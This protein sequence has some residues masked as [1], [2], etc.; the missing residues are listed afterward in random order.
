MARQVF[1]LKNFYATYSIDQVV[2]GEY[3]SAKSIEDVVAYLSEK[4][5]P[6]EHIRSINSDFVDHVC[7]VDIE[8]EVIP[9]VEEL[10]LPDLSDYEASKLGGA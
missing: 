6:V 2:M 3:V 4:S 7:I 5:I 1:I 9:L 8:D 10:A